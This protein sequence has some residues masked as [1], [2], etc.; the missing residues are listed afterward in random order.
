MAWQIGLEVQFSLGMLRYS[1]VA[2]PALA[3]YLI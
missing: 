3:L 1:K 2:A